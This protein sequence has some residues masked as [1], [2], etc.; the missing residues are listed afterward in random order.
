MLHNTARNSSD[1][2]ILQTIVIAHMLS[3][4]GEGTLVRAK[5]V[6]EMSML[7]IATFKEWRL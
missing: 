4:G 1:N 3:N 2:L 6:F 7:I 5:N